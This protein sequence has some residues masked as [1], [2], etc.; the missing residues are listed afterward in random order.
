MPTERKDKETGENKKGKRIG[1]LDTRK[2]V[3]ASGGL[4]AALFLFMAG[5]LVYFVATNEQDMVNNSYNSRQQVLLSRNYRGTI[6]SRDGQ[7]LAETVTDAAQNETRVYP[8]GKLFAHVV[9]YS[10][11]GR[12][13]VEAQAN[14]YLINTNISLSSKAANDMAGVK[15]PGDNVYTTLDVRQIGRAHV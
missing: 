8:F 4:F 7:V 15:N 13:G 11:K 1:C 6:Y 14:Y 3:L 10:T 9:G 12:T 2:A 5:F